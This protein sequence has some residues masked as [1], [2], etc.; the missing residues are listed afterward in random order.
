MPTEHLED[1]PDFG[2]GLVHQMVAI[3][4][5]LCPACRLEVL[6]FVCGICIKDIRLDQQLDYTA[7]LVDAISTSM[8]YV[9]ESGVTLQ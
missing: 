5:G 9:G 2:A 8:D 1:L 4:M 6:G 7:E 3:I